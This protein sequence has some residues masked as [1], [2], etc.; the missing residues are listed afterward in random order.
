MAERWP[1]ARIRATIES[2]HG[3][4]TPPRCVIFDPG[5]LDGAYLSDGDCVT[6]YALGRVSHGD[7]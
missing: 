4:I 6:L 5:K 1:L 7:N 3:S 2:F